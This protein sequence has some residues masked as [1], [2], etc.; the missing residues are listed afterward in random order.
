MD[1][2][3]IISGFLSKT[4]KI[5]D[6]KLD[7]LLTS[8]N[9]TEEQVLNSLLELDV[10]RVAELKKTADT[11]KFQE[12]YAKAKKEERSAFEN[13]IKTKFNLESSATGV[14]LINDLVSKAGKGAAGSKEVTEDDVKRHK[15]YQ[16]L[17]DSLNTKVKEVEQTWQTKY[18]D[19]EKAQSK[20]AV[21]SG[22][23]NKALTILDSL[24]P[25]LP[26]NE[27]AAANLKNIFAGKF[28]SY[29]YEVQ[30]N[31]TLILKDG[32]VLEDKHGNRV[33]L[34]DFIKQ[35][36]ASLF[37]FAQHTGGSNG[38]NGGAAGAAGGSG[39]SVSLKPKTLQDLAAIVD[40][41]DY[42]AEQ[43]DEAIKAFDELNK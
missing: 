8:E 21:V 14:D 20:N 7:E 36:A 38:A 25:V 35:E 43:K 34:E 16:D 2:K 27:Q 9:A 24:K 5:D 11:S 37:D 17:L 31:R 19:L 10:N 23:K 41:K 40:S 22:V 26:K 39:G 42:T 4:V 3:K 13:E 6:G 30:D 32:K 29:D 18:Q 12:G 33:D 1:L 28:E 15:T